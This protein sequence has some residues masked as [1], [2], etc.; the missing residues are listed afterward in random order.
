MSSDTVAAG[1]SAGEAGTVDNGDRNRPGSVSRSEASSE[2]A[3][4]LP[5]RLRAA[6][7]ARGLSVRGLAKQVGVSPSQIS[8]VELGKSQPSAATLYSMAAEL[9]LSID[10]LIFGAPR[11]QATEKAARDGPAADLA[12]AREPVAGPVLRASER[13][14]ITLD[15]GVV[16][17]QL[18]PGTEP[19]V[20]FLHTV[21]DVGCTS[22]TDRA[23]A[24]HA[25]HEWGVILSG[26]LEVSI[27]FDWYELGPGDSISFE[28]MIPHLFRNV[29]DEPVHTVWFVLGRDQ[30]PAPSRRSE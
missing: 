14:E 27:G 18:T 11:T 7:E 19:G 23:M 29:G 26:R 22:G 12:L 3:R 9:E 8:A 25:G 2:A 1:A 15:T 30:T 16:W 10:E 28:S 5:H 6:R 24:R 20:E 21:Y 13:P 17:E 4:E